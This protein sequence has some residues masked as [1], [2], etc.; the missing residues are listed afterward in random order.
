MDALR[1]LLSLS[2]ISGCLIPPHGR[3]VAPVSS[4]TEISMRKHAELKDGERNQ[5]YNL[6]LHST[7][8]GFAQ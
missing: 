6:I 3:R 5:I 8:C 2:V 4:S 1:E 7:T